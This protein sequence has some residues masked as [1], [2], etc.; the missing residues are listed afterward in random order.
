M[1]FSPPNTTVNVGIGEMAV[2]VSHE[3][4]L[5]THA[6]GSCLAVVMYD[7][8]RRVGGLVHSMLPVSRVDADKAREKPFMFVDLG[9]TGL[10]TAM[11][12]RGCRKKDLITRA[13]GAAHTMDTR[14]LFR[15]GE[16]NYAVFRKIMWKNGLLIRAEDVGGERARSLS[17]MIA[18]GQL[19]V[20]SEGEE[21]EL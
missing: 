17:L 15:I 9:V 21:R 6:L 11:F 10:L 1:M 19:M 14:N 20:R 8:V 2:S 7:P 5:T 3:D 12:N 16:R 13:A 18:T 4:V